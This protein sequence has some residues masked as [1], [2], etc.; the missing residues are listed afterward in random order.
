L[1]RGV[2]SDIG[3]SIQRFADAVLQCKQGASGECTYIIRS[4]KIR[5]FRDQD[6]TEATLA[7]QK[8]G[9]IWRDRLF[10]E[11]HTSAS[12]LAIG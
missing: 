4:G 3:R 9:L 12:A 5:I 11:N 7:T 6:G 10:E 2:G 8:P 1:P